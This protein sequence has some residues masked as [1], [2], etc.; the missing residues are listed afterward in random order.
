MCRPT[1]NCDTSYNAP[2]TTWLT[3]HHQ[4][5]TPYLMNLVILC[6][7][8]PLTAGLLVGS[9]APKPCSSPASVF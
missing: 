6:I 9:S 7:R 5:S 2:S 4:I 1:L 3:I 8:P